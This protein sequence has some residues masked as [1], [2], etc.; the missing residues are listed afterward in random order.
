VADLTAGYRRSDQPPSPDRAVAAFASRRKGLVTT[1]ELLAL[2]VSESGISRRVARGW[3]H[4]IHPGVYAVGHTSL[5]G[6]ALW[7]AAVLACGDRAVLSHRSAGAHLG[8]RP[9]PGGRIEV[10]VPG[11]G[12]P[13][14]TSVHVH[15]TRCL[16]DEDVTE[17]DG[18]PVTSAARTLV[19]LAEVLGPRQLK[20]AVNQAEVLELLDVEAVWRAAARVSGRPRLKRLIRLLGLSSPPTRSVLEERFFE[21]CEIGGLPL[22]QVNAPLGR[23]MV[24]F[25]W[26]DVRLVVETDGVRVHNTRVKFEEDRAR[27]AEL[28]AAGFRVVRFTWQQITEDPAAVIAVLRRLL[29]RSG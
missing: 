8:L 29:G 21:L 6:E 28:T 3:L 17:R 12:R 5:S 1:A 19:D 23:F 11:G 7:L 26:P 15:R 14:P 20:Y 4:R 2:G 18:I 16:T 22:P 9:V 25:F 27:D 13:G 10:T 24:D